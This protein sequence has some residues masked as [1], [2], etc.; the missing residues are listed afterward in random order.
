M[1]EEIREIELIQ[2]PGEKRV[3]GTVVPFGVEGI[4]GPLQA[5]PKY[6]SNTIPREAMGI[7]PYY[8]LGDFI[9]YVGDEFLYDEELGWGVYIH[10]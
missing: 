8:V 7:R 6:F 5:L 9:K 10:G 3:G 1:V 4:W 2:K